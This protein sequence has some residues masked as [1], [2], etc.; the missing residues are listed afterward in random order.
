MIPEKMNPAEEALWKAAWTA[1]AAL[2]RSSENH[3]FTEKQKSDAAL[4]LRDALR[5][6]NWCLSPRVGGPDYMAIYA[7]NNI[8]DGIRYVMHKRPLMHEAH[9]AAI[10]AVVAAAQAE[11]GHVEAETTAIHNDH[12]WPR[13]CADV[14]GM[15]AI[16][17]KGADGGYRWRYTGEE[18][19]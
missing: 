13:L 2:E 6:S 5:N 12:E 18:K 17:W 16:R 9:Q 7:A 4:E 3:A 19:T 8:H 15:D 10:R 14:T 11:L 1:I